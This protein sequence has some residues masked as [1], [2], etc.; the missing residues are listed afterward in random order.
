[1]PMSSG[2]SHRYGLSLLT[3]LLLVLPLQASAQQ[4]VVTEGG[5]LPPASPL[6]RPTWKQPRH[7]HFGTHGYRHFDPRRDVDIGVVLPP[8][9]LEHWRSNHIPDSYRLKGY[10]GQSRGGAK[11]C[12]HPDGSVEYSTS[13]I[14]CPTG[15]TPSGGRSWSTQ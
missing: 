6:E 5:I 13:G 15:Q 14:Q 1:M 10:D 3:A 12:R 9:Q 7:R 4:V 2:P 11:V 8:S